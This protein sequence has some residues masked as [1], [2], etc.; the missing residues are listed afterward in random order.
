MLPVNSTNT[1]VDTVED[2]SNKY[3]R[4]ARVALAATAKATQG[5]PHGDQWHQQQATNPN[6]PQRRSAG[7]TSGLAQQKQRT[8]SLALDRPRPWQNKKPSTQTQVSS[9]EKLHRRRQQQRGRPEQHRQK[10]NNKQ[11]RPKQG[12]N[13]GVS[14]NAVW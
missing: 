5:M 12:W 2:F 3:F 6:H 9:R 7:M 13:K 14:P 4:R 1:E 8:Q 11:S 10:Q